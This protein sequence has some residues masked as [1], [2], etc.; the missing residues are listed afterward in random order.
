MSVRRPSHNLIKTFK[1]QVQDKA[2]NKIPKPSVKPGLKGAKHP[3]NKLVDTNF[4]SK[5]NAGKGSKVAPDKKGEFNNL[6][7]VLGSVQGV[8]PNVDKAS[9]NKVKRQAFL[10]ASTG[11]PFV[12]DAPSPVPPSYDSSGA[13]GVN[14]TEQE[15]KLKGDTP[16]SDK[17]KP[18]VEHQDEVPTATAVLPEATVKPKAPNL[19]GTIGK[20][21]LEFL[22][23]TAHAE[24]QEGQSA[25]GNFSDDINGDGKS[26]NN[27]NIIKN[28]N[29]GIEAVRKPYILPNGDEGEITTYRGGMGR[30]EFPKVKGTQ[31]SVEIKVISHPLEKLPDGLTVIKRTCKTCEREC[32]KK[33]NHNHEIELYEFMPKGFKEDENETILVIGT[34]HGEEPQGK[35]VIDSYMAQLRAQGL[36]ENA[37]NR[38]IF[39][40]CLNPDGYFSQRPTRKNASKQDINSDFDKKSQIETQFVLS[41]IAEYDPSLVID[42]HGTGESTSYLSYSSF[43]KGTAEEISK[44]TWMRIKEET[45]EESLRAFCNNK[46][47]VRIPYVLMEFQPCNKDLVRS[48]IEGDMNDPVIRELTEDLIENNKTIR[49]IKGLIEK[50]ETDEARQ[51]IIDLIPKDKTEEEIEGL[52]PTV[53]TIQ[54]IAHLIE[55]GKT[56]DMDEA[57]QMIKGLIPIRTKI[58]EIGDFIDIACNTKKKKEEREEARAN[59]I[60]AII[61]LM[62]GDEALKKIK[63]L[64]EK[65]N[66]NEAIEALRETEGLTLTG[67]ELYGILE[68]LV[69][70]KAYKASPKFKALER[71]IGFIADSEAVFNWAVR[72][73][74]RQKDDENE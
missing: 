38:I 63:G 49:E 24:G 64:I 33:H 55:T 50:G 72:D 16:P 13:A 18:T 19:F 68:L 41:M 2:N 36:D 22:V 51:M 3:E 45:G 54:K 12:T 37:N 47:E 10:I 14:G 65:G 52:T 73:Y 15:K 60:D 40:P 67:K 6:L 9:K 32:N 4:D 28:T 53:E 66:T 61:N 62:P 56:K 74:V 8:E 35:L 23:P 21:V 30:W 27:G 70:S 5:Q 59:A 11:T 57:R 71:A 17:V 39:I 20:A 44:I 43:G 31:D 48:I 46:E 26:V 42:V 29:S 58:K 7:N 25:Q 34:V 69:D 1:A